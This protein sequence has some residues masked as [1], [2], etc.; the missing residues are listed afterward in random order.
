[1]SRG[2]RSDVT[3]NVRS[4]CRIG[5]NSTRYWPAGWAGLASYKGGELSRE[6]MIED[7]PA[8]L[9]DGPV[10]VSRR[11]SRSPWRTS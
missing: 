3:R 4:S 9:R 1:M 5:R 10:G 11:I 7:F 8:L 2:A 6:E